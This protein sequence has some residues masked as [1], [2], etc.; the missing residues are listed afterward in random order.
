MKCYKL[1]LDSNIMSGMWSKLGG[2]NSIQLHASSVQVGDAFV[3]DQQPL[4]FEES[5]CCIE[6]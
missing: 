2:D 4:R 5:I 1:N 3:E 6:H